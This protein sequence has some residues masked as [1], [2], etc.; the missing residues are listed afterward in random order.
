MLLTSTFII[1]LTHGW[2][3]FEILFPLALSSIFSSIEDA[4]V[5]EAIDAKQA[6]EGS[7][8]H[9]EGHY[10]RQLPTIV[11]NIPDGFKGLVAGH[12]PGAGSA[13]VADKDL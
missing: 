11:I 12:R 10:S 5:T 2:E 3:L 9:D 1:K 13:L 7:H 4:P 8:H 6:E